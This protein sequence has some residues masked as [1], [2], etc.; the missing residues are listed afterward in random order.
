MT[1][2]I[3]MAVPI[4]S[5]IF[6]SVQPSSP[7][8]EFGSCALSPQ[9]WGIMEA[10]HAFS[11]RQHVKLL[12]KSCCVCPPC[13]EQAN[14]YSIYAGLTREAQAEIMRVEE[15]SDD[16]NRCCCSPNHPFRLEVRQYIPI[17]G[18]G[19][20]SDYAHLSAD[21]SNDFNRFT[22]QQK[23]EAMQSMYEQQSPVL[24]SMVRHDGMRCCRLP[25]KC[26]ACGVCFGCC[27]DG[28]S[29]YAGP[30]VD[31][32]SINE[33]GRLS[34]HSPLNQ[35]RVGSVTQP[36]YAGGCHPT[37]HLRT[38]TSVIHVGSVG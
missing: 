28:M 7:P 5:P 18:D 15:K 21:F 11:I 27:I 16:W 19:S 9:L 22:D 1:S 14:T 32:K 38:G 8:M 20:D 37:F 26:L 12:P 36:M 29:L 10:S 34:D 33:V 13:V 23:A 17:P 25:C 4:A 35:R 2:K 30:I 24:L 6:T 31:D 3:H